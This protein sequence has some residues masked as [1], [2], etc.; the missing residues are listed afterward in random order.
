M[1]RPLAPRRCRRLGRFSSKQG[2]DPSP[3]SANADDATWD[4]IQ[5]I[6]FAQSKER[7]VGLTNTQLARRDAREGR[8]APDH[9]RGPTTGGDQCA[10]A[11]ISIRRVRCAKCSDHRQILESVYHPAAYARR[12]D[13]LMSM[14]GLDA[15]SSIAYPVI[16]V[17][18][19]ERWRL[20]IAPLRPFPSERS[21]LAILNC[22]KRNSS[23]ER[24][25]T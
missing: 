13:R 4:A 9:D 23:S 22:A 21:V 16:S 18:R 1:E 3:A 8:L 10:D 12:I 25:L 14:L 19:Y 24:F 2:S 20:C 5:F 6:I 17:S 7:F 15:A 11:L